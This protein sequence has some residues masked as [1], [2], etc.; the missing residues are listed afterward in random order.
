MGTRRAQSTSA[1]RSNGGFFPDRAC[2]ARRGAARGGPS[3]SGRAI[4]QD[5]LLLSS[6]RASMVVRCDK[7]ASRPCSA[8]ERHVSTPNFRQ[9]SALERGAGGGQ[10]SI[11]FLDPM[12]L[13]G[14]AV[15]SGRGKTERGGVFTGVRSI[16]PGDGRCAPRSEAAHRTRKALCAWLWNGTAPTIVCSPHGQRNGKTSRRRRETFA[17]TWQNPR[18]T[19][20]LRSR[21]RKVGTLARGPVTRFKHPTERTTCQQIPTR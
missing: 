10:D 2:R 19:R 8:E 13:Y 20:N 5:V 12:A 11:D 14:R 18:G 21:R 9:V 3:G 16:A 7:V 17:M 1:R 4:V 6:N 15:V